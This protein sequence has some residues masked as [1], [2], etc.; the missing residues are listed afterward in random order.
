MANKIREIS[1]LH[2]PITQTFLDQIA[3]Y[4]FHFLCEQCLLFDADRQLC[5]HNYPDTPHRKAYFE[6]SP[7]GRVLIFCRDFDLE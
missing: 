7:I 1:P 6:G 5:I 3:Q 4:H 2:G